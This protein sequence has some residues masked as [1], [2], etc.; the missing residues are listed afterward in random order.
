[1]SMS[2]SVMMTIADF[3]LIQGDSYFGDLITAGSFGSVDMGHLSRQEVLC[4]C[5]LLCVCVCQT[6]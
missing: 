3:C 6:L 4:V 1:M 2:T 5:V